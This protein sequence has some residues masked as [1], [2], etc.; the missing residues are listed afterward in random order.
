MSADIVVGEAEDEPE[1]WNS[2]F[3]VH[4]WVIEVIAD[5]V[6]DENLAAELRNYVSRGGAGLM[7]LD[8][9]GVPQM[10]EMVRVIR[11]SLMPAAEEEFP[12]PDI[13]DVRGLIR[14]LVE[15]VTRWSDAKPWW[16]S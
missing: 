8:R 16:T 12:L 11:E 10:R 15:M 9:F 13:Y 6:R 7:S 5:N 3:G 4:E 14:E 1:F 2:S